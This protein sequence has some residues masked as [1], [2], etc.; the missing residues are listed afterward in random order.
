MDHNKKKVLLYIK[1]AESI[2]NYAERL[3]R[4]LDTNKYDITLFVD[5]K[6]KEDYYKLLSKYLD[7]N[8]RVFGMSHSKY[9]SFTLSEFY[10]I[11]SL[12]YYKEL[13]DKNRNIINNHFKREWTRNFGDCQF[14]LIINLSGDE[15]YFNYLLLN[16]TKN[17]TKI[18]RN[19]YSNNK[20]KRQSKVCHSIKVYGEYDKT[21]ISFSSLLDVLIENGETLN[22]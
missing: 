11:K 14:D 13:S 22:E 2:D 8:V 10:L 21:F 6:H 19:A 4:V 1:N 7:Y 15:L 20:N 18:I 9:Y 17:A 5:D 16:G 3:I 12:N